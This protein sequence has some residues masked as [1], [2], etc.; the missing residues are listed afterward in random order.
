MKK[1]VKTN[2]RFLTEFGMTG[3]S[4]EG[5]AVALWRDRISLSLRVVIPNEVRFFIGR[6]E[7]SPLNMHTP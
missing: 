5:S 1:F 3:H 2:D 7:E 6:N 4:W